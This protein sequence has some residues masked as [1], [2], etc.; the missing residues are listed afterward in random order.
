MKGTKE[1][2]TTKE[3]VIAFAE[4]LAHNYQPVKTGLTEYRWHSGKPGDAWHTTAELLEL[5]LKVTGDERPKY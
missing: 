2:V 5:Y 1:Q 3:Q 4:W